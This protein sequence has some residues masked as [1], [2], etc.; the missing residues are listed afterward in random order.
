MDI[1]WLFFNTINL[2]A[3]CLI[4]KVLSV[5]TFLKALLKLAEVMWFIKEIGAKICFLRL[6][7]RF[8]LRDDLF[9][10]DLLL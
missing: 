9:F 4:M 8:T 5:L 2:E 7:F 1:I 10:L 3:L 6:Q